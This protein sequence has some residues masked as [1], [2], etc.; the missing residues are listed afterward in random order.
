MRQITQTRTGAPM[1]NCT[2]ASIASVL[3]CEDFH[4][5]S[6]AGAMG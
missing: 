5:R 6:A 3:E 4:H 2:E 1:G